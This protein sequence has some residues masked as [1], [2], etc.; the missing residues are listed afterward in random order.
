MENLDWLDEDFG[1]DS[2]DRA[3]DFEHQSAHFGFNPGL[4]SD[5]MEALQNPRYS[6]WADAPSIQD[7]REYQADMD[8]A[9]NSQ[10]AWDASQTQPDPV[11]VGGYS[12]TLWGV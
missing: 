4:V 8:S 9:Y 7:L 6:A 1:F 11:N 3:V 12:Q 5:F 2:D 10:V